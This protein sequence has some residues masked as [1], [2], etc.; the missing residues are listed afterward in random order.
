MKSDHSMW[1]WL[2]SLGLA[3]IIVLTLVSEYQ[4]LKLNNLSSF[5]GEAVQ[6]KNDL[7]GDAKS[8][9]TEAVE[10]RTVFFLG[11]IMLARHV[12]RLS[13]QFGFDYPYRRFID[14]PTSSYVVANFEAAIPPEHVRTPDFTFQFSVDPALLPALR[15]F[16][17]THVSLANNHAFDHG[18]LGYENARLV[19]ND[20]SITPFGHPMEI[21]ESTQTTLDLGQ[22][23]AVI[24]GLMAID[25]KPDYVA[26]AT[27]LEAVPKDFL[28]IAYI[29]WG[30]EYQQY[31]SEFQHRVAR[32]LV[33]LGFNLII[34]HH[35]HVVQSIALI[36]GVP[37]FYSLGNFIFDQYFSTEVQTGLMLEL[38]AK[39]NFYHLGLFG[40]TSLDARTQPRLM[41]ESEAMPWFA[42]LASFSDPSL[43]VDIERQRLSFTPGLASLGESVIMQQ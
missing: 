32:D 4:V 25:T 16:G 15:E 21:T 1:Q 41:T 24:F 34:G 6:T 29:H 40:V 2:V 18:R 27:Q 26:L 17:V 3:V 7:L 43:R 19:L 9:P 38:S 30:P 37:V 28:K 36:D 13:R 8:V 20:N 11:D 33:A 39:G 31:P 10:S 12:E 42:E 14:F 35:P 5:S 23:S 22:T